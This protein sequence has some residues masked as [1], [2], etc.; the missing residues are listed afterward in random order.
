MEPLPESV[1]YKN[2]ILDHL[3]PIDTMDFK[4]FLSYRLVN[5]EWNNIISSDKFVIRSKNK[6]F[7]KFDNLMKDYIQYSQENNNLTLKLLFD[8]IK[9]T[10]LKR[11]PEQLISVFD[12]FEDY[13][14][15]P[16]LYGVKSTMLDNLYD[17]T[18]DDLW[19][20][21]KLR[22]THSLM[23][24]VD[25]KKRQFIAVR[26]FNIT[27]K[28][29][30]LECLYNNP[31]EDNNISNFGYYQEDYWTFN[32]EN[33]VCKLGECCINEI[34]YDDELN[35]YKNNIRM[36]SGFSYIQLFKLLKYPKIPCCKYEII[37]DK[38]EKLLPIGIGQYNF[39]KYILDNPDRDF[40]TLNYD[41]ENRIYND[42]IPSSDDEDEY[43]S[44]EE[45][46]SD[47]FIIN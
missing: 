2:I 43:E 38:L 3:F 45:Y 34:I 5:K 4:G 22:M 24:G 32:G 17:T 33:N 19:F 26:Y 46:D 9:Y 25:D 14:K 6:Y 35:A 10:W 21:T 29:L 23:R 41:L 8:S 12:G 42:Y 16:V 47:D 15:L 37:N 31:I 44:S 1:I 39:K 27:S 18:K 36:L 7:N 40:I 28:Q 30:V 11:F 13:L 20:D